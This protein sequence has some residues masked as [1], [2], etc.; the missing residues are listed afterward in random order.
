MRVE[1][2]LMAHPFHEKPVW[3]G[4]DGIAA[5]A[6]QAEAVGF[7][8][9]LVPEAGGHDPFFPLLIAAA[10][11]KRIGLRTGVAVAFPRS[12]LVMAQIAWDLKRFSNG[13]FELGLGTQVKGQNERRYAAPWTT[14]PGPRL[15]EYLLCMRAMFRTF[16]NAGE[17]TFFQGKHYQFTLMPEFFN[18]GPID[19]PRVPIYVA[20]VNKYMC[21]IAGELCEG[22]FPHPICTARFMRQ[23]MFPEIEAGARKT[24]RKRSDIE[25]LVSPMIATGRTKAEVERKV[26]FLKQ[27]LGFYASTRSYHA[28]VELHGYLDVGQQLFKLSMEAKWREMI[29]LVSD[30]ML[31]DFATVAVYDELGAKL[32]ERWGGLATVLHLDLPPEVREDEKCVRKIIDDLR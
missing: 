28:P 13:R 10:N 31:D 20:A 25:V 8:G 23:M 19:H 11:T 27:R 22:I 17:P 2:S 14:A 3:P 9:V 5:A 7:D 29:D 15:R 30:R 12:P 21:R 18:P 6:R 24:G 32:K 16:Q 1:T 26:V 4:I